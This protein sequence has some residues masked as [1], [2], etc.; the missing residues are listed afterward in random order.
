MELILF[1]LEQALSLVLGFSGGAVYY[2]YRLRK[3]KQHAPSAEVVGFHVSLT[4]RDYDGLPN[5]EDD[6]LYLT[7]PEEKGSH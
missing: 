3:I 6:V 2:R 5:K 7:K 4:Q 1:V